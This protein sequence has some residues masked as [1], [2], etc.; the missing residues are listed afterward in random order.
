MTTSPFDP[1]G[2]SHFF[3][4]RDGLR[5]HVRA[6]AP[7]SKATKGI[8]V[9]CL[10]GLSR[11]GRDFDPLARA[12]SG[13]P[14]HAHPVYCFDF[15]G[16]GLSGY[17]K[18]WQNYNI[19][20]EAEDVVD[21]LTALGVEDAVFVGTSRGGLVTMVLA[22]MRPGAIK[23]VVFNDIGP[24]IDGSGLAQI[25]L[26]LRKLPAPR[27][28][29]EAADTQR[30][31]MEK[32]FT[33][34]TEDDFEREAHARFREINGDIRPDHD[35]ALIKTLTDLDLEARLPTMWPQ[36][37]GL[38]QIPLMVVRGENSNLLSTETVEA[39]KARRKKMEIVIAEQQGHAPLLT[40]PDLIDP[41]CAFAAS[42]TR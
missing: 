36:F 23:A 17:D 10:P 20:K 13:N 40:K 26:Y 38:G 2:E 4:A 35:P 19:L 14:K 3:S 24:V 5:I 33:A 37:D 7:A 31:V 29:R 34:L 21:G 27:D 22:A 16:R 15:R 1:A 42:F 25:R 41:I 28:W 18:D 32:T 11:N 6:Y 30:G 8:P 12:L 9:V 39:M